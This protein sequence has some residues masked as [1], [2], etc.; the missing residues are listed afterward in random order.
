[1]HLYNIWW[2]VCHNSSTCTV[3][4]LWA[5]LGQAIFNLGENVMR[6]GLC[7]SLFLSFVT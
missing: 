7:V 4:V 2:Y 1:M 6:A 3:Y 5:K